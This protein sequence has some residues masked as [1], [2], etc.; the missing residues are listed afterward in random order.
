QARPEDRGGAAMRLFVLRTNAAYLLA[1]IG[2][3]SCQ[4]DQLRAQIIDRV[5]P[6]PVDVRLGICA[7]FMDFRPELHSLAGIVDKVWQYCKQDCCTI[8]QKRLRVDYLVPTQE[9]LQRAEWLRKR[10]NYFACITVRCH[11]LQHVQLVLGILYLRNAVIEGARN[12]CYPLEF[13]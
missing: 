6:Y 9:C 11:F 7:V 10:L 3:V 8:V 5:V 12:S 4:T 1:K 2:G 13:E